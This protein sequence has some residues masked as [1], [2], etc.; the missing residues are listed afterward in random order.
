MTETDTD[1]PP[2]GADPTVRTRRPFHRPFRRPGPRT[3][4]QGRVIRS[5]S[6][7]SSNCASVSRPRST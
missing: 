6:S 5:T 1:N 4:R 7:A 3:G 2:T